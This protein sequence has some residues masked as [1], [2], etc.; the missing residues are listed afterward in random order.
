MTKDWTMLRR[1]ALGALAVLL[2]AT[3]CG[4]EPAASPTPEPSTET[5][6]SPSPSGPELPTECTKWAEEPTE[7]RVQISESEIYFSNN[8]GDRIIFNAEVANTTMLTAVDVALHYRIYVD[9][10]EVT[11]EL[12]ENFQKWWA[13]HLS[14]EIPPSQPFPYMNNPVERGDSF[15][16]P[17]TWVGKDVTL[18]VE[19]EEPKRWCV[20]DKIWTPPELAGEPPEGC[21]PINNDGTLA[22]LPGGD[23]YAHPDYDNIELGV[24]AMHREGRRTAWDIQV[25]MRLLR[26]GEDVTAQIDPELPGKLSDLTVDYVNDERVGYFFGTIFD[27]PQWAYDGLELDV[28][29]DIGGW[30]DPLA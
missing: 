30:C 16:T 25:T 5:T 28:Q 10:E 13:T 9:G 8:G 23:V 3:G 14:P 2:M 11:D 26:H 29:Y 19:T 12:D 18:Q 4:G 24:I 21:T 20:P 17:K 27:P 6:A 15:E 7:G 22:L 1:P